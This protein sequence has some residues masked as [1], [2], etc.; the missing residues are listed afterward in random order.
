MAFHTNLRTLLTSLIE[1]IIAAIPEQKSSLQGEFI[2]LREN[3]PYKA[4]ELLSGILMDIH[5][6]LDTYVPIHSDDAQNPL[7]KKNIQYLWNDSIQNFI[8]MHRPPQ[9]DSQSTIP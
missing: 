8:T 2:R 6:L 9:N 3:L 7:W 4:P 5:T 1:G